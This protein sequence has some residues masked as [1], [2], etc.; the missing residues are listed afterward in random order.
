MEDK[1]GTFRPIARSA[2]SSFNLVLMRFWFMC[3]LAA[4][5]GLVVLTFS[6][7]FSLVKAVDS[8]VVVMVILFALAFFAEYVDSSLGMGYGTTLT[9][10]LLI[11]GFSPLQIVPAVLFSEFIAGISAGGLHHRLGNV[12]LNVRTQAGKSMLIL[13]GCSIVGTVIAVF[14][15]LSLPIT[16]VKSYIGIMILLIGLF[17]IFGSRILG[18]FSW[19]KI[20]G[21]GTIAAFNKGISGGGYGPLVTG[22]QVM[23]GVSGKNAIG[24]TL[25]AEGLVCFVG[26]T[27]YV[28][29]HGWPEWNLAIPLVMGAIISVP[30]A[31]W[32][33][34]I[35]PERSI[36]KYIGYATIFLGTLTLVK[37]WL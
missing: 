37:L 31:T 22:G 4:A 29:F 8:A 9:P 12:D 32:T 27:L 7:D 19:S 3:L 16:V 34:K 10:V 2:V 33:V 26:L 25:L 23:I 35:L 14:F 24:I 15:A 17:I 5:A 21:L 6:R 28:T 18:G 20:V 13:A 1:D 36:R 30:A 11:M